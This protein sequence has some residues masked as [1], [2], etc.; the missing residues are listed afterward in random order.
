MPAVARKD[1]TDTIATNHLCDS[2]T[3]TDQG[4]SNVFVNS[5]GVVRAGDL[6]AVHLVRIGSSCVPHTVPLSSHSS[7]VF[8]NGK[9]VGRSG[10][11]YNGHE[12]T[13]G[14]SNVF[15]G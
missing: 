12:I 2:T 7:T 3:A 13:S 5:K 9:G 10:D 4:S 11:F 8:I 1:G 14:S 15:A 6:C